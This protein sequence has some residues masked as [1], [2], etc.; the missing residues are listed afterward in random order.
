MVDESRESYRDGKGLFLM[1]GV[2]RKAASAQM[3]GYVV[4]RGPPL[5]A[6]PGR[7]RFEI[8]TCLAMHQLIDAYF[9][10]AEF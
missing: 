4:T 6:D 1:R 7:L 9:W 3:L 10:L 5:L 8:Y 2:R